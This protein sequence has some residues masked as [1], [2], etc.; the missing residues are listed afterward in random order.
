MCW[1]KS[2]SSI[3]SRQD[4]KLVENLIPHLQTWMCSAGRLPGPSSMPGKM[5]PSGAGLPPRCAD[6]FGGFAVDGGE[7]FQ[8]ALRMAARDAADALPHRRCARAAAGDQ[9]FGFAER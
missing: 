7:A 1:T 4:E 6:R 9:L 5:T 2:S 8:I 3:R